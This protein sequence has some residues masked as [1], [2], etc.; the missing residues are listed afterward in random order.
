MGGEK[1]CDVKILDGDTVVSLA[2]GNNKERRQIYSQMSAKSNI[3]PGGTQGLGLSDM[4]DIRP[5]GKIEPKQAAMD[6]PVRALVMPLESPKVVE[7]FVHSLERF[8]VPL[9]EG[10]GGK[11]WMQPRD[12]FHTTVFHLS[13]H[14]NP[15]E[16]DE[17]RIVEETMLISSL[18][19]SSHGEKDAACR[20]DVYL[21]RIVVTR[22]GNLVACWQLMDGSA[23]E[24]AEY[25]RLLQQ[26]FPKSIQTVAHDTVIH[27]TL[28]RV[29]VFPDASLENILMKRLD[30]MNR[31]LC[32]LQ[33]RFSQVWY[34]LEYDRLALALNG[35]HVV[36]KK[37]GFPCSL[38]TRMR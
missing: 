33:A 19:Q 37:T 18:L 6:V 36:R 1:V 20:M 14:E 3:V 11:I 27:M 10:A 25:R 2:Q 16:A 24:M 28:A 15:I 26:T 22:S 29:V 38:K 7:T 32:G 17:K 12:L 34:I 8:I 9:I 21:E 23:V 4:F 35:R 5:D 13:T 30:E 31:E